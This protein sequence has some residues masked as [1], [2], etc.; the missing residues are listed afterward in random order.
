MRLLIFSLLCL[1]LSCSS[2]LPESGTA[3]SNGIADG[4]S[5][6]VPGAGSKG[7]FSL[8]IYSG[9][10]NPDAERFI[11][12]VK[13]GINSEIADVHVVDPATL[14]DKQQEMLRIDFPS[15]EGAF[16]ISAS[17]SYLAKLQRLESDSVSGI[18]NLMNYTHEFFTINGIN[19]PVFESFRNPRVHHTDRHNF[20]SVGTY[21]TVVNPSDVHRKGKISCM[22]FSTPS[23]PPC[24]YI[25]DRLKLDQRINPEVVDFYFVDLCQADDLETI[26]WN[27]VKANPSTKV[28]NI[29]G[30]Q[31]FPTIWIVSPSG[32]LYRTL[33]GR[34]V[35]DKEELYQEILNTFSN[36]SPVS[37]TG[38]P[39]A[40]NGKKRESEQPGQYHRNKSPDLPYEPEKPKRI[41]IDTIELKKGFINIRYGQDGTMLPHTLNLDILD[42]GQKQIASCIVKSEGTGK[43]LQIERRAIPKFKLKKGQSYTLRVTIY[44][45]NREMVY[46]KS[47][48]TDKRRESVI[49][50]SAQNEP[51]NPINKTY[52]N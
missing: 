31:T 11:A 6:S 12:L 13:Q 46:S 2:T 40:I 32:H 26:T 5:G 45:Q 37:V 9:E 1:L 41:E 52:K 15:L 34:D 36:I 7:R 4:P 48:T 28:Y 19:G 39:I 51:I 24:K 42:D 43:L 29:E 30:M 35:N 47:F 8:I 10:K 44:G 16:V 33:N 14:D 25:K 3:T 17:G 18:L 49:G 21:G 22:V 20:F 38:P 23:C 50:L 27:K